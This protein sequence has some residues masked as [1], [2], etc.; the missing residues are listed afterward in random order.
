ME[1]GIAALTRTFVAYGLQKAGIK[2]I[3]GNICREYLRMGPQKEKNGCVWC[4]TA[5]GITLRDAPGW[6]F[7][8]GSGARC[9]HTLKAEQ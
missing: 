3:V 5:W 4:T 2:I 6:G 9:I 1:A 8:V 7:A